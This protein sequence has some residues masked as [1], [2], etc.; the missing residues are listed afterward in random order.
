MK[1]E[2]IDGL[3]AV[4]ADYNSVHGQI[5]S[6]WTKSAGAFKW[7]ITIPANTTATI[8]IPAKSAAKVREG[9]RKAIEVK[10]LKFIKME[11]NRAVFELCSGAYSFNVEQ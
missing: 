3:D 11:G 8:S 9:G 6:S 4:K 2:L 1:P 10:E 5:K 7:D